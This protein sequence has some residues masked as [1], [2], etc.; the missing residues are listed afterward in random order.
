MVLTVLTCGAFG[1]KGGRSYSLSAV[2]ETRFDL[3]T[4]VDGW[5]KKSL[6]SGRSSHPLGFSPRILSVG[7]R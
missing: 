6:E 7:C 2:F 1:V 4:F 3:S 5:I